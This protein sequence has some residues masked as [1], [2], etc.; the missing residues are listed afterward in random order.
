MES[1]QSE[2]AENLTEKVEKKPWYWFFILIYKSLISFI[3]EGAFFHGA[4]L[5]YYT[6]FAF[7]PI[8]YLTTSIFGR[9]FGKETM[10]SIISDLF[11]NQI[12]IEDSS[13]IMSVLNGVD[14]DKPS[15]WMEIFSITI[16]VY[17]CSA[18]L[19]SLK[20][21][22]NDFFRIKAYKIK[23]EN[24]ILDFVGFRFLSLGLLAL[25]ALVVILFYF[26]QIFVF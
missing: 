19:V 13:G 16:V 25:F 11:K 4:A 9:V 6:L 22:I 3:R 18:F 10:E 12:G 17:T 14:F 5:A 1:T 20:R 24:I 26:V 2:S 7:V 8:V 23:K 21:S 15:I